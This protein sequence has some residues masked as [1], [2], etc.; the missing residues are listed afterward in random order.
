MFVPDNTRPA[1]HP[2]HTTPVRIYR[3]HIVLL[4]LLLSASVVSG[5]IN[6]LN[7]HREYAH[8]IGKYG[9]QTLTLHPAN[10]ALK[11]P[12]NHRFSLGL[13]QTE[14]MIY[15]REIKRH[16]FHQRMG[17]RTAEGRVGY[18][19]NQPLTLRN[20]FG[21]Q[22]SINTEI[23]HL[24]LSFHTKRAGSFGVNIR[25]NIYF[26]TD[27]NNFANEVLFQGDG[28]GNYIDTVI[29]IILTNIDNGKVNEKKVFELL[30]DSYLKINITHEIN[31]GYARTLF[32]NRNHTLLGG[33]RLGYVYGH[34]DM[35]LRFNE[36]DIRGYVSRIPYLRQDLGAIN[37][38]DDIN[39]RNRTGH[40]FNFA[41]GATWLYKDKARLGLSVTDFGLIRWPVNPVMI[42]ENLGENINLENGLEAAF[43]ELISDGIFYYR[44]REK[45]IE[46]LPAKLIVGAS[47][48]AHPR[49]TPYFDLLVPLN[50]SPKNFVGPVMGI[51][52]E[53][54]GW[55]RL[56]FRTGLSFSEVRVVMPTY[57]N[58]FV[59]KKHG[60]EVGVGTADMLSYFISRRDYFQFA[61]GFF[62]F[63]FGSME[64]NRR[65]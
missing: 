24:G 47:Y 8:S 2:N 22:L 27:F 4:L 53:I 9:Y 55:D 56:F 52:A 14:T 33:V 34:A 18:P 37:L 58:V 3:A 30:E 28:F 25:S 32:K 1:N 54:N 11:S 23:T 7:A 60:Y 20:I 31:L 42:K 38:P 51:G 45:N 6:P 19:K 17:Y 10:L 40:G 61:T 63:H 59:G 48:Q 35:A 57:I 39:S 44:G 46:W 49:I 62:R 21:K 5:Q 26:E 16:L 36:G 13:Y 15:S 41:T 50:V 64:K 43:D 29:K 65:S 12:Q